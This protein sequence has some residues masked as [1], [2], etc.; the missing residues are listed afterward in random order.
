MCFLIFVNLVKSSLYQC[1]NLD[2]HGKIWPID[3]LTADSTIFSAVLVHPADE[4]FVLTVVL[5][6]GGTVWQ[7]VLTWSRRC[8]LCDEGMQI[9]EIKISHGT[10]HSEG[11]I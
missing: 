9:V 4:L 5:P 7:K 11:Y 1:T 10:V 6:V 2:N 3:I 8:L